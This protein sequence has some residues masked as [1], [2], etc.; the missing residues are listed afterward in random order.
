MASQANNTRAARANH[1]QLG[2]ATESQF[3]Q[4]L[5]VVRTTDDLRDRLFKEAAAL[6]K[7]L[8]MLREGGISEE[9]LAVFRRLYPQFKRILKWED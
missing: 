6:E 8:Q 2:A 9:A 7:E 3:T 5:H 1:F 4:P